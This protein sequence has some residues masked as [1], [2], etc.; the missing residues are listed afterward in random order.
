MS[1]FPR[2]RLL[3][4]AVLAVIGA[5][6]IWSWTRWA[7]MPMDDTPDNIGNTAVAFFFLLSLPAAVAGALAGLGA[8]LLPWRMMAGRV[9]GTIALG[10]GVF[11]ALALGADNL[12]GFD[13]CS[14]L[15]RGCGDEWRNVGWAAGA[16]AL[17]AY[18][19]V[20]LWKVRERAAEPK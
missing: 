16:L 7:F 9:V 20:A 11:Y 10:I 13:A 8:A 18:L 14:Q 17:S 6:G 1:L 4:A 19:I 2:S 12:F 15:P 5:A 3:V